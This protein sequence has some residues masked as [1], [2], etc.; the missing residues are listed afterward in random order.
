M[1]KREGALA[2]G[3]SQK[4]SRLPFLSIW[5]LS[6]FSVCDNGS[7]YLWFSVVVVF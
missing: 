4:S 6:L 5:L 2:S 7:G 1:V 3:A